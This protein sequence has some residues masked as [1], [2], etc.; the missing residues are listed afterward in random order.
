MPDPWCLAPRSFKHPRRCQAPVAAGCQPKT[1]RLT[2]MRERRWKLSAEVIP[3]F[4]TAPILRAIPVREG[5][6]LKRR[7]NGVEREAGFIEE[8]YA[9]SSMEGSVRPPGA[10]PGSGETA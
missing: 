6:L 3:A 1:E 2:A 8:L 9:S 7:L 10:S 4:E 5:A